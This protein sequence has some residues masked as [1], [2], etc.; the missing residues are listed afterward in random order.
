MKDVKHLSLRIE[1]EMLQKFKSV[2]AY[3]G[4]SANSQLLI[5][6]RNSISEFEKEHGKIE[7]DE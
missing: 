5:F 1:N 3:E 6:I 4:R 2:C 7:I